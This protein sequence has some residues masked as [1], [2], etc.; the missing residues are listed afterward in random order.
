[1]AILCLIFSAFVLF[2]N[3]YSKIVGTEPLDISKIKLIYSFNNINNAGKNDA[4]GFYPSEDSCKITRKSPGTSS[5]ALQLSPQNPII[6]EGNFEK[7]TPAFL[8]L[9]DCQLLMTIEKPTTIDMNIT[10]SW[11]GKLI[12]LNALRAKKNPNPLSYPGV[13]KITKI[14]I[15][16]NKDMQN[17]S[18]NN[19]QE[20]SG[21]DSTIFTEGSGDFGPINSEIFNNAIISQE[22]NKNIPAEIPVNEVT[23]S[24]TSPNPIWHAFDIKH[25]LSKMIDNLNG[26]F[27]EDELKNDNDTRKIIQKVVNK[28]ETQ[29]I[30]YGKPSI[31]RIFEAEPV[32][33]ISRQVYFNRQQNANMTRYELSIDE[34]SLRYEFSREYSLATDKQAVLELNVGNSFGNKII[35]TLARS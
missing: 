14:T 9:R 15:Y 29:K 12:S 21:K 32:R 23:N 31:S 35:I 2:T 19:Y 30:V 25:H 10:F 3:L 6:L 33:L 18:L 27:K 8:S 5:Q 7:D 22:K 13:I 26:Y 1:M 28:F 34:V 4:K 20:S 17:V 24:S 16:K 11:N